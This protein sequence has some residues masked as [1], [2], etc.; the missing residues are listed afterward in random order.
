ML[1]TENKFS[2][3]PCSCLSAANGIIGNYQSHVLANSSLSK[4]WTAV[5]EN[6]F[7]KSDNSLTNWRKTISE[8]EVLPSSLCGATYNLFLNF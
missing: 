7:L 1:D 2:F 6:D 8:M 4:L 5:M 3:L